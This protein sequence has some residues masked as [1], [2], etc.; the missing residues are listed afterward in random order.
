MVRDQAVEGE[1]ESEDGRDDADGER[2]V[3]GCPPAA[4]NAGVADQDEEA[5]AE[6][7]LGDAREVEG[8]GVREDRHGGEGL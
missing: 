1:G 5:D 6:E 3:D 2:A 8:S 7:E 4:V